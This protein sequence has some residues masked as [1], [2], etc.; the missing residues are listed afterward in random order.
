MSDARRKL[1]LEVEVVGT[2][3]EVW[4]AIATGPG[5][6]S[7]YVPHT[8]EEREGGAATASF[9]DGPEMQIPGRV[10]A[11]EPPRRIVF[12]GVEDAPGLA[13]EWL[14][15]A[16]DGGSC[17]VRLVNTGFGEG[18]E[19]DDQY[20]G[21]KEGWRLFL[22]NL[23]LHRRHFSGR[24]ARSM[25]PVGTWPAAPAD[26][27]TRLTAALGVPAAPEVGSKLTLAP[28]DDLRIAGTVV[29]TG[30]TWLALLL[31]QP[32]SGTAF[33]AV[34][35]GGDA[36]SVSVWSYLYGPDAADIVARDKARWQGWLDARADEV[37]GEL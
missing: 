36:S 28:V 30:S 4:E 14:I 5:I 12:E 8:V 16:R 1:E 29:A 20:D 10:T 37:A 21:M 31:D 9:G 18:A 26:S 17:V 15:E 25:L 6:T 11:W 19:W 27:W 2:P 35:G 7:W 3:E 33:V 13:F 23:Q 34:E 32:A 22:L 24:H